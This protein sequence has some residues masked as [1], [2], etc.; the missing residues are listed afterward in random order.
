MLGYRIGK[1]LST[2]LPGKISLL[3]N[4]IIQIVIASKNKWLTRLKHSRVWWNH[5]LGMQIIEMERHDE[6]VCNMWQTL[7]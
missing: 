1:V 2:N 6:Y 4:H 7:I 3:S 5:T